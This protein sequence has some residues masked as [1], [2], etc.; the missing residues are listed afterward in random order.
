MR[1]DQL[2]GEERALFVPDGDRFVPTPLSGGPWSPEHQFGGSAA[3]LLA[4]VIEDLPTI[5]PQQVVRLTVD[6]M[7][8]VPVRPVTV[9]SQVVREGKRIQVIEAAIIFEDAEVAR[10]SALRMRV[11]DLGDLPVDQGEPQI[12]PPAGASRPDGPFDKSEPPGVAGATHFTFENPD[13]FFVDPT[14]IRMRV[15]V[16]AGRQTRPLARL[17]FFADFASGIGHPRSLPVTGINAD[18]TLNIVRYPTDEWLCV[19]GTGWTSPQ[20]IGLSQ[21]AISDSQGVA[22][23]ATLSR[24]VDPTTPPASAVIPQGQRF[25]GKPRPRSAA[26]TA[27]SPA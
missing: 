3:A 24:L 25:D 11:G 2:T 13:G 26:D 4:T 20:G 16:V 12:G 9:E 8:P 23:T 7:R 10:C 21:A 5:V 22:A 27:D 18:I 17:A 6:L 15:P 14:W 1:P 19:T